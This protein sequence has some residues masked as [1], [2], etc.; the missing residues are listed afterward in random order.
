VC[1]APS[2]KRWEMH[3]AFS[4][5]AQRCHVRASSDVYRPLHSVLSVCSAV[6]DVCVEWWK[7]VDWKSYAIT[8]LLRNGRTRRFSAPCA[9]PKVWPLDFTLTPSLSFFPSLSAERELFSVKRRRHATPQP[10]QR[11]SSTSRPG[12]AKLMWGP[13]DE[14]KRGRS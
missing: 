2:V 7:A 6:L 4:V 3:T 5:V 8:L 9:L 14:P 13:A 1:T 12:A 11:A 10:V